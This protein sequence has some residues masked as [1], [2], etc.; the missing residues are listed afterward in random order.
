MKAA[1][2]A[3]ALVTVLVGQAPA[4]QPN[5]II[6]T[7]DTLRADHLGS[8]G[9]FRDTSPAIDRLSRESV[10]FD[11]AFAPMAQTLPSHLS[12]MTAA[13]PVRHGILTN[14]MTF[15]GRFV[16]DDGPAVAAEIFRRAGYTTAAFTSSSPLSAE[17]GIDAGFDIFYGLPPNIEDRPRVAEAR[18]EETMENVLAWLASAPSPFLLWI[19]LFDPH[20]PYAAPPPFDRAYVNEPQLFT[21]LDVRGL[22]AKF[23]DEAARISNGYDGEVLYMDGQIERL[24][25]ALR[26]R[27]LYDGALI[28]FTSDHGEGMLQHGGRYHERVWNS[29]VHVPLIVRLP[30][31]RR[32]ERRADV[33]SLV[34]VLPTIAAQTGVVL[35]DRFDG[36][37]LLTEQRRSTLV[38]RLPGKERKILQYA[39]VTQEWKYVG[40]PT[41]GEDEAL[42]HLA[43]DP[44]ERRNVIERLPDRAAQMRSEM[45][46]VIDHAAA[47]KAAVAPQPASPALRERLRQL[48]YEE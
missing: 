25:A 6:I 26:A 8:Y 19:H 9:Y 22:N 4:A 5:V 32:I 39:L 23:V 29:E 31:G 36:I 42:F 41:A 3:L 2:L 11:N 15:K 27:R 35:A 46:A 7:A 45:L 16:A 13:Y 37:D 18:A 47:G 1:A 20:S 30:G 34:D 12:L 10:H 44:H 28:V 14:L 40:S 24:F 33:A 43:E 48:G 21:F 38:Q 17:T